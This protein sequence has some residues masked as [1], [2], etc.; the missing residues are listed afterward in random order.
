MEQEQVETAPAARK[1][2]RTYSEQEAQ[3]LLDTLNTAGRKGLKLPRINMAFTP[4]N[5]E[6]VRTMS[7][8]RGETLTTFVNMIIEQSLKDNADLYKEAV[9]FRDSFKK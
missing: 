1:E 4:A 8:V 6:Y 5:Y 9:A 2:R 7:R 3:E